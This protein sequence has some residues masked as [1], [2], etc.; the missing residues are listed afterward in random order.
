VW[1]PP[2]LAAAAAAAVEHVLRVQQA[3]A[4]GSQAGE[5]RGAAGVQQVRQLHLLRN[6]SRSR[7]HQQL[8]LAVACQLLQQQLASQA[9]LRAGPL[10]QQAGLHHLPRRASQA[11]QA[12]RQ[13]QQSAMQMPWALRSLRMWCQ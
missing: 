8:L 9:V 4:A 3:G 1:R 12:P 5:V 7:Q 2:A 11:G 13:T 10:Q 6:S